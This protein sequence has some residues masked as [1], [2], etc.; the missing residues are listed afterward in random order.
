MLTELWNNRANISAHYGKIT[1]K[2]FSKRFL[3]LLLIAFGLILIYTIV[4][5]IEWRNQKEIGQIIKSEIESREEGFT[6]SS[7]LPK[8]DVINQTLEHELQINYIQPGDYQ[9]GNLMKYISANYLI[10]M[11]QPNIQ[12]RGFDTL[13]E[14]SQKYQRDLCLPITE[15]E[16]QRVRKDIDVGL[17]KLASI[18]Y[19]GLVKKW[20]GRSFI[21]KGNMS[22]LEGGMP[23]THDWAI[24]MQPG[25]F[26]NPGANID[27]LYHEITHI[28][29]REQPNDF[30]ALFTGWGFEKLS[31][32][33]KGLEHV[34]FRSRLNPDALPNN[35]AWVWTPLTENSQQPKQKYW[36]GCIYKTTA[37]TSL[38]E[39][40]FLAY[41]LGHPATLDELIYV[42]AQ[43]IPLADFTP[44]REFF[45][46]GRNHYHPYEL[47]A[48]FMEDLF[49]NQ[50]TN[51]PAGALFKDW[52][53][54]QN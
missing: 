41:P 50:I 49:T 42:G 28:W 14:L 2:I 44:F 31:R 4:R 22:W 25:W 7:E 13:A 34:V 37:P 33:P 21:T 46:A 51:N 27:I 18:G 39:V 26:D 43:P 30:T 12:A 40:E 10:Y 1:D 8:P 19:Q 9:C 29:Q 23:H 36:I 35:L 52:I 3:V 16:K 11:N 17:S 24:I 54:K 53:N 20:L 47:A 48:Q 15:T 38:H 32:M 6:N 45:G 5:Y